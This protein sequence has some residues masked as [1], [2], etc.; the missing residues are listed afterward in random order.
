MHSPNYACI[1]APSPGPDARKPLGRLHIHGNVNSQ[2]SDLFD[3]A[4]WGREGISSSPVDAPKLLLKESPRPESSS[5]RGGADDVDG[6]SAAITRDGRD[7]TEAR[8]TSARSAE[9]SL[10]DDFGAGP[11]TKPTLNKVVMDK[12]HAKEKR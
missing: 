1:F 9:R 7:S 2:L 10:R 6:S 11:A 12:D 3:W 8:G 5:P 4:V